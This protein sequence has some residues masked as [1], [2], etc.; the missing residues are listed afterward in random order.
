MTAKKLVRELLDNCQ[1]VVGQP[2]LY[3]DGEMLFRGMHQ[4]S[5]T[6]SLLVTFPS[7]PHIEITEKG[8]IVYSE[9]NRE[10]VRKFKAYIEEMTSADQ[11]SRSANIQKIHDDVV[12][13]WNVVNSSTRSVRTRQLPHCPC[14]ASE[15]SFIISVIKAELAMGHEPSVTTL[16]CTVVATIRRIKY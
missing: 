14:P 7:T 10:N 12:K 15:L 11:I 6:V 2:V 5:Y 16:P 9:V 8:E 13:L 1:G 3:K 4:I